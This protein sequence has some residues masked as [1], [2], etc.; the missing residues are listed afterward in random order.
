M[1]FISYNN[2]TKKK[3][4]QVKCQRSESVDML[5]T[6]IQ[7]LILLNK[8]FPLIPLFFAVLFSLYL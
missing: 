2:Y 3:K 7:Y 6:G 4:K 1:V 5:Q 8:I